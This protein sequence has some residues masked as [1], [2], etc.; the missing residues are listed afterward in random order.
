MGWGTL[1]MPRVPVS[2][3][4]EQCYFSVKLS[5][6]PLYLSDELRIRGNLFNQLI[7]IKDRTRHVLN[8]VPHGVLFELKSS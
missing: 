2:G 5:I 8:F 4:T 1:A 7:E 3:L 6:V